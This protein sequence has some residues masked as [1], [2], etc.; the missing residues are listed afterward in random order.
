MGWGEAEEGGG[1][2]EAEEEGGFSV[3][4]GFHWKRL[5]CTG[6]ARS[7]VPAPPFPSLALARGV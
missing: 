4:T 5:A 2:G 6:A 7:I 3:V 1:R